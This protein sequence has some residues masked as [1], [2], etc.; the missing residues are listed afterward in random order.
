MSCLRDH[1]DGRDP[2]RGVPNRLGLPSMPDR[3]TPE[4][5]GLLRVLLL[6]GSSLSDRTADLTRRTHVRLLLAQ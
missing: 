1:D 3:A 2:G 6:C 4:A 5:G